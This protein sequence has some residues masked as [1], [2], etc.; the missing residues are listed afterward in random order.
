MET[1]RLRALA[2]AFF[3]A[4]AAAIAAAPPARAA[5]LSTEIDNALKAGK[6]S[7]GA[8]NALKTV[9]RAS[10]RLGSISLGNVQTGNGAI[11]GD[12]SFIGMNWTLLAYSGG[13]TRTTFVGFGPKKIFRFQDI[14]KKVPGIELLDVIK[15]SDQM[16]TFSPDD[17]ELDSGSLP[18]NVRAMT[19]KFFEKKD[20]SMVVP[21]GVTQYGNFDLGAA[22][23][24]ADAIKFLGGQSSKVFTRASF[25]GNVIDAL[26]SGTPPEATITLGAALPTF[27]PSIGGKITMPADVQFSLFATL[28]P[29]EK[30][31]TLGYAGTTLFRIG[32]Q[33]VNMVLDTQIKQTTGAPEISL[34]A[35]IFQGIPWQRAFGIPWLTI[36]DYR[37]T[38]G[39][40]ADTVKVG[41]GGKTSIGSKQFDVFTLAAVAA[42][43]VGIPIPERIELAINDGPD[44]I[45][46]IGLKD[47]ASIYLAMINAAGKKNLR[48]PKEFPDVAIAGTKVGEGPRIAMALKASG[49]AGI[50]MS[51]ALRILDTNIATVERAFIQA[52]QGIEIK[53]KT[54]NLG[55]GPIKFPTA[56]VN[57]VARADAEGREIPP[58]QVVI[59]TTGLS[60]FGSRSEFDLTMKLTQFELRALQNFG[61]LLKFNFLATTGEEIDS[62]EHLA[63]ADLRLNASLSSD[64]REWIRTSGKKAVEAAFAV[65]RKDVDA[66]TADLKKAQD[67]VASL[68]RQID[69]MKAQV[70]KERAEPAKQLKAAE[71]EVNKLNKEIASLDSQISSLKGKIHTCNQNKSVCLLSKPEKTGC[72]KKILGKCVIPKVEMKCVKRETLP[73]LPA[74]AVCQANNVAPAAELAAK[75]TAKGTLIASRTVA[76]KTLEGLRKGITNIP[77]EL[78][79][80]VSSLIVARET[81][82]G[83]LKAAEA[84]VK[85]FG[86]FTKLLTAGI[87]A[88]GKP[89]VFALE[90]SSIEGSMRGSIEGK[91]VVLAMNFRLLG[92]RYSDRFAFSLTD[93]DFNAKQLEVLALAAA[94]KTVIAAGKQAKIIPHKL[95]DKVNDIY[96]KKD[97]EVDEALA[98]ALQENHVGTPEK[99]TLSSPG[100]V[101]AYDTY[102]RLQ[103]KTAEDKAAADAEK[104][105][106]TEKTDA[107]IVKLEAA[108]QWQQL[109]G[110]AHDI[111]V[112]AAGHVW[113]IGTNAEGGGYGIYRRNGNAWAKVSGSAVRIDVD[114]KGNPW[115]VNKNHEIYRHD[116][117]QWVKMPGAAVD[118][119]IGAGGHVW[120]IGTNAEGGGYG[121]YRWDGKA[122]VKVSGSAVRID[123]DPKG[124]PWVVNKQSEIFRWTGSGW[125]KMPGAAYDVGIG[126]D[127]T[128][129]VVGTNKVGGGYGV[130]RWDGRAWQSSPGGLVGLSVDHQGKPWG[131]NDKANIYKLN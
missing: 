101:I 57:V 51:G 62:M 104:K 46:Q 90:Q 10:S 21:A 25:G 83:V 27:R 19:D 75:E 65:V 94:T 32:R 6:L 122:W 29:R 92:Q 128:V 72:H 44:K 59:K 126:A 9:L 45:G 56:D 87:E 109:D 33:D 76:A 93:W 96:A 80:R 3:V 73:D 125:Q 60:L 123:V 98:K 7:S 31:A 110:A 79:P 115:V 97:R 124:N 102:Q 66:A 95:L 49:E 112:G 63:N 131:V 38:F 103:Q 84:T 12:V 81:A 55:V 114:P 89:D 23:P 116:G 64:P 130:W 47:M 18:A 30:E 28:K 13:T 20:Y 22:K 34:T 105:A 85:G 113:V 74:R 42:K 119:G 111:G 15:F 108:A 129:W 4:F 107:K 2:L 14:V 54:A 48:I 24:L 61:T 106:H 39:Q 100:D 88:V 117:K 71:D 40:E 5:S 8:A 58:P 78:D 82:M 53:A 43:T 17:A 50:D 77:L 121:I 86:E 68:D 1:S 35:T 52:D 118:I 70:E 16:L 36:E 99:K 41:I 69:N 91:P 120:V 26:L 67:D 127:G 37:M 11:T